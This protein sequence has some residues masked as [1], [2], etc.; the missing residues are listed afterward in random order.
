MT[1]QALGGSSPWI[2]LRGRP[3]AVPLGLILAGIAL[4]AVV[5]TGLL[6]LEG[7]PLTV[8]T[9]KL[10]TGWA[11]MTCGSTRTLAHLYRLD[12]FGALAMNPLATL[13]VLGLLP[14][15]LGD[16]VLLA[17]GRA[18]AVT[19]SPG[20]GRLLRVVAVLAVASNWDYLLAVGR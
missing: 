1:S 9:F 3:G 2:A 15:A 12:L 17:R 7:L 14:W 4:G 6:H 13:S 11:C 16:L 8:C 20:L 5:L 10:L 18:L 19:V